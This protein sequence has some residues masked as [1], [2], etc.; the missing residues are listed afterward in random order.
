MIL[1]YLYILGDF[2]SKYI[3]VMI[4]SFKNNINEHFQKLNISKYVKYLK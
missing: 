3:S 1:Y 4:L 2:N